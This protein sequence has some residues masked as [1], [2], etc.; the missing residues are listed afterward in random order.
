MPCHRAFIGTNKN[1]IEWAIGESISFLIEFG[2]F[3]RLFHC[4]YIFSR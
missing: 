1:I 4:L 2:G 3:L